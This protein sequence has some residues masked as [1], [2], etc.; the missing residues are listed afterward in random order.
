M[1][2]RGRLLT[3]LGGGIP[4]CVPVSP[5][6]S[7]MVPCRMTGK[8]FWGNYLFKDPP[9]WRAYLEAARFF[10]N[11]VGFE[12]YDHGPVDVVNDTR[13]PGRW[14]SRLLPGMSQPSPDE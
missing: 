1:T 13:P 12:L 6:F 7:N 2:N 3:V 10:G 14:A 8:P 9:L 11:D 5:D 4:D